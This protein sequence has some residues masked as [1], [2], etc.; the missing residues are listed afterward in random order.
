MPELESLIEG[1]ELRFVYKQFPA[2][3]PDSVTAALAT[4][5]ALAQGDFWTLHDWLFE[6]QA[7]WKGSGNVLREV[8]VGAVAGLG[9]NADVLDACLDAPETMT[10]AVADFQETQKFGFRGTPSF[11]L[12]GRLF[13]GFLPAE[14]MLK[15]YVVVTGW[16]EQ[17]VS[18]YAFVNPLVIWIWIGGLV[19]TLG[20]LIAWWPEGHPKTLSVQTKAE[21]TNP[22]ALGVAHD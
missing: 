8:I 5:C 19:L 17:G 14:T 1:G 11:V 18:F 21:S 13:P 20:G 16:D 6:Q 9:Y 12:N 2:L 10:A 4:E 3:G 15:L 7:Q 22:V